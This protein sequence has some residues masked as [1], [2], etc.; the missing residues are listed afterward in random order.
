MNLLLSAW[1]LYSLNGQCS[2]S[3]LGMLKPLILT[4]C[5]EVQLLSNARMVLGMWTFLISENDYLWKWT[6]A[7]WRLSLNDV[8]IDL[9][10]FS[11]FWNW[12]LLDFSFEQN[13]VRFRNFQLI[14]MISLQ[15]E[16][17]EENLEE[18]L[19][20]F[21]KYFFELLL[22][23]QDFDFT[24]TRYSYFPSVRNWI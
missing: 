23:S 9:E 10:K 5:S 14:D 7:D 20:N 1:N 24:S 12:W 2:L 19:Y 4:R 6:F 13:L 21:F 11:L 16:N 8:G 3:A 15:M 18:T 17:Q 22:I